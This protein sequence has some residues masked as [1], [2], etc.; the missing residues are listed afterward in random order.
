MFMSQTGK[1][2]IHRADFKFETEALQRQH[3]SIAKRL[4]NNWVARIKIA[5][6]H[7]GKRIPETGKEYTAASQLYGTLS[8]PKSAIRNQENRTSLPGSISKS[9]TRESR[10]IRARTSGFP[11]FGL[12]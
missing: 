3:L 4:R 7:C 12:L 6:F 5:K 2:R 8:N 9:S 10:W 1:R 11:D